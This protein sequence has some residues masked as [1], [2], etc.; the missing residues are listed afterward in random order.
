MRDMARRYFRPGTVV[1]AGL[2]VGLLL[3]LWN[4]VSTHRS[5]QEEAASLRERLRSLHARMPQQDEIDMRR[6]AAE[7]RLSRQG[8]DA[9]RILS[10]APQEDLT[11]A[12]QARLA[13]L[14]ASQPSIQWLGPKQSRVT[15]EASSSMLVDHLET[16]S[17]DARLKVTTLE[18]KRAVRDGF[19]ALDITVQARE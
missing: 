18:I 11:A 15:V 16:W 3:G 19:V 8:L 2:C 6:A 7:A 5:R 14:Q 13:P 1:R 9:T 12:I 4:A 10:P 17:R